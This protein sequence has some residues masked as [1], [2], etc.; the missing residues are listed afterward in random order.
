[1]MQPSE[2]ELEPIFWR[3]HDEHMGL[4]IV[5]GVPEKAGWF[6]RE[7]DLSK[8]MIWGDTPIYGNPPYADFV[9]IS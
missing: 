8:W 5:M 3:K 4:S 6:M 1:M 2:L 9:V 7:N